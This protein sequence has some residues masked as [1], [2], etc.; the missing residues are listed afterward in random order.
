[1]KMKGNKEKERRKE[2]IKKGGKKMGTKCKYD[3]I[4]SL[5][6]F[7]LKFDRVLDPNHCRSVVVLFHLDKPI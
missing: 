6:V 2:N 5:P 7:N 4:W 3:T 1:M